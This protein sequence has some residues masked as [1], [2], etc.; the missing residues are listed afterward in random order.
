[1][2]LSTRNVV[3]LVLAL[4]VLNV[5]AN[6]LQPTWYD[7]NYST[8]TFLDGGVYKILTDY[9]LPNN[10]MLYS[11]LR[12]GWREALGD[13]VLLERASTLTGYALGPRRSAENCG[14]NR[15]V[16]AQTL[17]TSARVSL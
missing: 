11:L 9:H 2:Q 6:P 13:G 3:W 1:M 4:L 7:E 8:R 14:T 15:Q 12:L 16:P 10:H 5:A 17:A